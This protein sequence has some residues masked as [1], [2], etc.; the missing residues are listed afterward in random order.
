MSRT[1]NSSGNWVWFL[2]YHK[3]RDAGKQRRD[4]IRHL[5]DGLY[6]C[7]DAWLDDWWMVRISAEFSCF[8]PQSHEIKLICNKK[9]S[10]KQKFYFCDAR[11]QAG[12]LFFHPHCYLAARQVRLSHRKAWNAICDASLIPTHITWKRRCESVSEKG[13]HPHSMTAMVADHVTLRRCF[14]LFFSSF[15]V[16]PHQL[17]RHAVRYSDPGDCFFMASFSCTYLEDVVKKGE[18][19]EFSHHLLFFSI[20]ALVFTIIFGTFARLFNVAVVVSYWFEYLCCWCFYRRAEWNKTPFHRLVSQPRYDHHPSS[21]SSFSSLLFFS[22]TT[23]ISHVHQKDAVVAVVVH[24]MKGV[25]ADPQ[26]HCLFSSILPLFSGFHSF[27]PKV[28]IELRIKRRA[29]FMLRH[30]AATEKRETHD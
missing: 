24:M 3:K 28:G 30:E 10:E 8:F 16:V 13:M 23:W 5:S 20:P 6:S 15:L 17:I 29:G 21:A 2:I 11:F 9:R 12:D 4:G 27:I 7:D 1:R 18:K 14:S 25:I 19:N 26:F 22:I